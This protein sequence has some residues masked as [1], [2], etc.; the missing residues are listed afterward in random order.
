[1]AGPAQVLRVAMV[2]D[3]V[4]LSSAVKRILAKYKGHVEAVDVDVTYAS[5]H[6]TSGE[7]FL[8]SLAGGAEF[9][10]LLLD[11]K[12]PGMGGLEILEELGRQERELVTIMITAYATFETAVQATKL[13]AFD[14]L[15]KP[16]SPEELRYSLRKATNQLIIS[17]EARRLAEEERQVRFNFIS[18][19]SHELK[20]PLNAIEG[21]LKLLQEDQPA[22]QRQMIDRSLIRLD[23]MRKLIFD[24]L[25]L[26]RIESGQKARQFAE[27]DVSTVAKRTMDLFAT[28]A[29][30]RGI[31]VVLSAPQPVKMTADPGELEI[32][33]NN[34][35]SNAVKYNRDGGT[36][37][38][39]LERKDDTVRI[40]VADTGIGLTPEESAKLFNEFVRIKNEDTFKILGSGLGLSTV[41][42]LANL[43]GGEASVKSEKGV[44]STFTVTLKDAAQPL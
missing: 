26:T 44:G 27:V 23:G 32:V 4:P 24:L 8:G 31:N 36:V 35:V 38:V 19:L 30:D 25:D 5:T 40:Q 10:L 21:Y 17:R 9:D 18:V 39:S 11:L 34:L 7:E 37:S 3:E 14:F 41:R 1:M 29:A 28:E 43:Y 22:E 2:D 13:G 42:K 33:F 15:A 16:F 12:L 20:A 6:F